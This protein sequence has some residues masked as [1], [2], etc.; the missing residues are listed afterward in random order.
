VLK[1]KR[2]TRKEKREEKLKE[3]EE[4][5]QLL[6]EENSTKAV[7]DQKD[8][9]NIDSLTGI[10]REEDILHFAIP[11]VAPYSVFNN[12]KYKVKLTPGHLKRG[13]AAKQ[14]AQVLLQNPTMTKREKELIKNIKDEDLTSNMLADVRLHAPNLLATQKQEKKQKK[15]KAIEKANELKE[16]KDKD[17][18]NNNNTP[19]DASSAT[20]TPK[21]T[22]TTT[23]DS[24]KDNNKSKK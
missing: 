19:K 16:A 15:I 10:P 8:I 22:S 2:K 12:Y 6:E 20:T 18:N 5:K 23:V 9:T 3:E 4:I 21:E 24:K 7:E 11:V 1:K 17:N 13:K 14:A